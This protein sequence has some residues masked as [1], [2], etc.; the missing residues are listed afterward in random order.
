[1]RDRHDRQDNRR[2]LAAA[3]ALAL[4]CV[5]AFA[6]WG[7]ACG[8]GEDPG[9]LPTATRELD[10]GR[11]GPPVRIDGVGTPTAEPVTPTVSPTQ[12][13]APTVQLPTTVPTIILP[14]PANRSVPTVVPAAPPMPTLTPTPFPRVAPPTVGVSPQPFGAYYG[15]ATH[16]GES[17][18]GLTMGCG[19]TYWSTDPY[20][21]AV[22]P[23]M[24]A[25]WP[26]GTV[27][28]ITGPAGS[29]DIARSDSCPGCSG[30]NIDLSEAGQA[31]ICGQVGSNCRVS[32]ERVR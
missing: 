13:Y 12:T 2:W 5:V 28:R 26:C 10:A 21:L 8:G 24:Y 29:L 17:Y 20:I 23:A 4:A 15:T 7:Q 31:I 1:M 25:E 19:G 3:L 16:Y 30:A 11:D 32:I 27:L 14:A 22:G 9:T 18:N 6:L